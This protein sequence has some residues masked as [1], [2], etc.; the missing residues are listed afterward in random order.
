MKN[1]MTS[2]EIEPATFWLV[3]VPAGWGGEFS[4]LQRARNETIET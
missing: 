2:I 4:G 1:P 3:A